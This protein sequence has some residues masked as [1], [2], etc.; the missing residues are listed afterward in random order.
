V[1]AAIEDD[2]VGAQVTTDLDQRGRLSSIRVTW[3][4]VSSGFAEASIR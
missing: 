2:L 3:S 1:V 4:R